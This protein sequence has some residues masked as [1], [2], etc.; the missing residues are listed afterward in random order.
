MTTHVKSLTKTQVYALFSSVLSITNR[1]KTDGFLTKNYDLIVKL[2]NVKKAVQTEIDAMEQAK[3]TIQ[4]IVLDTR[5]A[6]YTLPVFTEEDLKTMIGGPEELE[7]F[8]I[9]LA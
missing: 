2:L 4:E 7:A 9:L 3:V 1:N 5:V 6:E 8:E